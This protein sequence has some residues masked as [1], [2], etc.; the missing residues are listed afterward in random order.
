MHL[1]TFCIVYLA[2]FTV[3]LQG[4]K[5]PLNIG[6]ADWAIGG[7]SCYWG[8]TTRAVI[9]LPLCKS[10]YP[11]IKIGYNVYVSREEIGFSSLH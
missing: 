11:H 4:R 2:K 6:L 8:L 5:G 7:A 1:E 3:E 9:D 10:K